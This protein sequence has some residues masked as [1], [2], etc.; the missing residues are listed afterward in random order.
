MD[1]FA[2]IGKNCVIQEN[3]ALGLKYKEGCQKVKIGN[4]KYEIY[5]KYRSKKRSKK[6]IYV[7]YEDEIFI[8][9]GTEGVQI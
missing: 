3:V 7:E 4:K 5:T 8:I 6:I 9:T 1:Y 2:E